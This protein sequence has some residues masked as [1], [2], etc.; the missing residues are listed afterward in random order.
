MKRD[1]LLMRQEKMFI[2]IS[3]SIFNEFIDMVK[4]VIK[5]M[6]EEKYERR[7]F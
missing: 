3:N 2:N 1:L 6:E 5:N 4:K 7:T